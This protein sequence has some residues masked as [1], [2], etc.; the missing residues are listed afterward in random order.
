[1]SFD[2]KYFRM[3]KTKIFKKI[4]N[5]NSKLLNKKMYQII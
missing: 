1:M 2:F 4:L 3:K 5:S